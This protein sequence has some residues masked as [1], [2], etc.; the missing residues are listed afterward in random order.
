MK[1]Y[2]TQPLRVYNV[3]ISKNKVGRESKDIKYSHDMQGYVDEQNSEFQITLY[4]DRCQRICNL[5][6]NELIDE[7][8]YIEYNSKMYKIIGLKSTTVIAP[9]H[10][11][12][13]LEQ[14]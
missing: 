10:H 11:I 2:N 5:Y 13:V 9:I 14:L 8:C 1:I 4:G 7:T 6:S 3:T 12:Y